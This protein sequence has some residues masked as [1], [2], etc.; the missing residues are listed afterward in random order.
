LVSRAQELLGTD[1][2][3][4]RY[5]KMNEELRYSDFFPRSVN[6]ILKYPTSRFGVIYAP[7]YEAKKKTPRKPTLV[8]RALSLASRWK[9]YVGSFIHRPLSLPNMDGLSATDAAYTTPYLC[10]RMQREHFQNNWPFAIDDTPEPVKEFYGSVI[11]F[12]EE[13]TG[14]R[15]KLS[16]PSNWIT[17]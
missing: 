8:Q 16:K 7:R 12:Y 11:L 13:W 2:V 14:T 10:Y 15:W 5:F 9:N 1:K 4:S 17:K 6:E 3:I